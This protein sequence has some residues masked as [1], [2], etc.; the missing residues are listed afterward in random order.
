[1]ATNFADRH[2]RKENATAF[3]TAVSPG[4]DHEPQLFV[5]WFCGAAPNNLVASITKTNISNRI[6]PT[7]G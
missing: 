4:H 6:N 5:M 3:P 2:A 1:M 7:C